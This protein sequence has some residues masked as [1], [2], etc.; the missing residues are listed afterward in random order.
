MR[1]HGVGGEGQRQRE[2]EDLKQ[3]PH[4]VEPNMG[5]S[6]TALRSCPELKIKS[7]T[8]N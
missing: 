6:R 5:L 4:S 3:A 2:T 8:L 7:Q 1:E